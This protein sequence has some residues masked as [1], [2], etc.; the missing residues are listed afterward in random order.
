M[1]ITYKN[2]TIVPSENAIGSF[3][4]NISVIRKKKDT[5]EEYQ[6]YN[7]A[8]Y[9]MSFETCIKKIINLELNKNSTVVSLGEYIG[10]YIAVSEEVVRELNRLT[11]IKSN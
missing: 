3:D 4:L 10:R 9:G 2:Y 1:E 8:G 6:S 11:N 7:N 5:G